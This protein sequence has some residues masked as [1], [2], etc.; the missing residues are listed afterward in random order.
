MLFYSEGHAFC[1]QIHANRYVKSLILICKRVVI[2]VFHIPARI[3]R[4]ERE[5]DILG[6][7]VLVQVFYI[8]ESSVEV[9]HRPSVAVLIEKHQ[10]RYTCLLGH[11]CIVCTECWSNMH[12]AG[13]VFG[14]HIVA[15]Y[16]TESPCA[17]F[18]VL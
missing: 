14:G 6:N 9:Y 4:I 7:I 11:S 1:L 8:I 5:I 16:Y 10:S 13:T 15:E 2:C 17:W 18:Y 12:N 3:L